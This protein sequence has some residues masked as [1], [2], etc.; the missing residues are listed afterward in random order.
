[1][2]FFQRDT[3][4]GDVYG[5][6]LDNNEYIKDY[7]SNIEQNIEEYNDDDKEYTFDRK[8]DPRYN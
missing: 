3:L 2:G 6:S 1:M 4:E 5:L 8:Y 7:I